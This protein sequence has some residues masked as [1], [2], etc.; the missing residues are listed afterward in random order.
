MASGGPVSGT[1]GQLFSY[2]PPPVKIQD[3][4]AHPP[5]SRMST[6]F[7]PGAINA[8]LTK[9]IEMCSRTVAQAREVSDCEEGMAIVGKLRTLT[10]SLIHVTDKLD[11]ARRQAEVEENSN[12]DLTTTEAWMEQVE[13]TKQQQAPLSRR[14]RALD[15]LYRKLWE[16]IV[17]RNFIFLL[18][19]IAI[20]MTFYSQRMHW[21]LAF[22]AYW[23]ITTAFTVG[24][25]DEPP[26]DVVDGHLVNDDD[27][28]C[29]HTMPTDDNFNMVFTMVFAF[30]AVACITALLT[31]YLE[32]L[33]IEER[34][35][36]AVAKRAMLEAYCSGDEDQTPQ[37]MDQ[38]LAEEELE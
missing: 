5:I 33:S 23:T 14:A 30:A 18:L 2:P 9:I 3:H 12:R 10:S 4:A 36:L 16:P 11:R 22:A 25:G 24:Y 34:N 28:E 20:G 26:C 21:P 31:E 29:H 35:R 27:P 17:V 38:L 6:S 7:A 19:L 8:E 13:E 15:W 37:I 1:G 32:S